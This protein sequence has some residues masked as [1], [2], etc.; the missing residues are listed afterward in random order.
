MTKFSILEKTGVGIA[1]MRE[2]SFLITNDGKRCRMLD[3]NVREPGNDSRARSAPIFHAGWIGVDFSE[4]RQEIKL[5]FHAME[6]S[7]E[8]VTA[9]CTLL[10]IPMLKSVVLEYDF[11]RWVSESYSDGSSASIRVMEIVKAATALKRKNEFFA[12]AKDPESLFRET[13]SE[14]QRLGAL[15]KVWRE[16][17][18]AFTSTTIPVLKEFGLLSRTLLIEP[19]RKTDSGKFTFI[20]NDFTVYG[21][22]WPHEGIGLSVEDQ[23]DSSYGAWVS[24]ALKVMRET[25]MPQYEHIDARIK[26]PNGEVRRSRY[27]CLRTHW[28]DVNN[29]PIL[30]TISLISPNIDIPLL[31]VQSTVV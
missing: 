23:Y 30:M 4:T 1:A 14:G 20:G 9:A 28:R 18:G 17:M 8:A 16:S 21:R 26:R 15:L 19:V 13:E 29:Y 11:Y 27:K 22:N 31:P 12:A 6:I 5:T 25:G 7:D 10:L 3:S 24:K 2:E